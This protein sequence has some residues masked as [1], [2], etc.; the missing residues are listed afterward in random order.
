[1]VLV[2]ILSTWHIWSFIMNKDLNNC[3]RSTAKFLI[4]CIA[5]SLTGALMFLTNRSYLELSESLKKMFWL[6]KILLVTVFPIFLY[7]AILI[8]GILIF[9]K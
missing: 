3:T 7:F 8:T 9:A 6:K 1:M 2:G 4:Y 5:L